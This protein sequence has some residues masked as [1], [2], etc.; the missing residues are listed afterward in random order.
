MPQGYGEGGPAAGEVVEVD[1][2][3]VE[4]AGATVY[5]ASIEEKDGRLFTLSSRTLGVLGEAETISEAEAIVEKAL[6]HIKCDKL[7]VRHDIG[8]APLIERRIERM[9]RIRAEAGETELT[10]E[11][12]EG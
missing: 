4:D 7:V 10:P 2:Q 11:T 6:Q 5:Y 12:T 8:T 9:R 1:E 3:A